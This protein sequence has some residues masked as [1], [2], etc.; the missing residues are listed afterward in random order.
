[1]PRLSAKLAP[2]LV[3]LGITVLGATPSYGQATLTSA[4]VYRVVNNVDLS[5]TQG[6]WV[7]ASP[8]QTMVPQDTIRTGVRSRAELLFNEGTLVRTGEGTTFRFP[9]GRRSFELINGTSLFIIRPNLG[10]SRI[11]TPEAEIIALGTALFVQH[12]PVRNASIVGVLT[13]SPAGPVTVTDAS[14]EVSV[15]LS[16]GQ[17]VSI[18]DGVIGF[19]EYFLLPVFYESVDLAQGL[20][21]GQEAFIAQQSEAVQTTLT[22]VRAESIGPFNSQLAWLNGLCQQGMNSLDQMVQASPL[23]QWLW[24]G[25]IP[26]ERIT[27][28]VPQSDLLIAPL[29]SFTGLTWMGQYCLQQPPTQSNPQSNPQSSPQS[30]SQGFQGAWIPGAWSDSSQ[31]IALSPLPKVMDEQIKDFSH[32]RVYHRNFSDNVINLAADP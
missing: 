5:R 13:E 28:Q 15:Q 3:G 30:S 16:A 2:I 8:G 14:G 19:I 18:A 1:M 12:D 24:P 9:A 21:P 22:A 10:A 6:S 17:F 25:T 29:R 4:E 26:P 32:F 27:L 31:P 11:T 20:A 23:L 7:P